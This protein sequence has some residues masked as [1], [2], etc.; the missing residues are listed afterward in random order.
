MRELTEAELEGSA[1]ALIRDGICVLPQLLGRDLIAAWAAAFAALFTERQRQPGGLAGRDR[2]RFYLTLPWMA[3]FCTPAVFANRS[4]LGV[5]E[6]VL[7]KDF[8]FV[9]MGV[10]TPLEGSDYQE[11][12]RDHPPLFAEEVATPIFALAVNFPLC[13]VTTENGPLEMARGTHRLSRA[14]G[15]AEIATGERPLESFPMSAGDVII[16]API[17]LHRG[18]PNRTPRPRPMVVLGFVRSW[19]QTPKVQ[20]T[21]P[22]AQYEALPPETRTLLRC[23]LADRP[24]IAPETYLHFKY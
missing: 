13:D 10:D 14:Q 6:R 15:L 22:R 19:L 24:E 16:R 4:I 23:H 3:P 7:G 5:V 9:Q 8:V 12:H 1:A 21:V 2:A 18:T 20:L 11:V 17:A